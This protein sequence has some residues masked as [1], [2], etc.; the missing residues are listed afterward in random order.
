MEAHHVL[1][2]TQVGSWGFRGQEKGNVWEWWDTIFRSKLEVGL[3]VVVAVSPG[4]CL[5]CHVYFLFYF[6]FTS[7]FSL[8]STPLSSLPLCS[9]LVWCSALPGLYCFPCPLPSSSFSLFSQIVHDLARSIGQCCLQSIKFELKKAL[10]LNLK[11]MVNPLAKTL[12]NIGMRNK[13]GLITQC[14]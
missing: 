3:M 11:I 1:C 2:R 12:C 7:L 10:I 13:K 9:G 6:I 4:C 5:G 8:H 14:R